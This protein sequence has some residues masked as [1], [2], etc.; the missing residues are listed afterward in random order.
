MVGSVAQEMGNLA[1]ESRDFDLAFKLK[2]ISFQSKRSAF[3]N[4][5]VLFDDNLHELS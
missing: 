3:L 4:D 1:H 5:E 2:I